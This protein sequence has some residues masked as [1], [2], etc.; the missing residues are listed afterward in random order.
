MI[1]NY[2]YLSLSTIGLN[3]VTST[4]LHT[5]SLSCYL[6]CLLAYLLSYKQTIH[7]LPTGHIYGQL[8]AA[9]LLSQV[10]GWVVIIKLKAK[11]SSN[12]TELGLNLNWAWQYINIWF[13]TRVCHT[14]LK[15]KDQFWQIK[16]SCN[17]KW[18]SF[19]STKFDF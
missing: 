4:Y 9:S 6:Q 12:W 11:L 5:S 14:P 2:H 10:G 17:V 19:K 1:T 3:L 7:Q 16:S 8:Q 13:S 18:R 15:T